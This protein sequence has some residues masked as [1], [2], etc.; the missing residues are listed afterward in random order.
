[1]F[2]ETQTAAPQNNK[3]QNTNIAVYRE[4][5]SIQPAEVVRPKPSSAPTPACRDNRDAD[6]RGPGQRKA[7]GQPREQAIM[8][9]CI[10]R[11]MTVRAL[12][13]IVSEC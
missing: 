7:C 4:K 13:R 3:E 12:C 6:P 9:T 5:R 11:A 10:T 8:T 1:M 2:A